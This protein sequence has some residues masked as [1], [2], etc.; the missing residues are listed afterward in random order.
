MI[1]TEMHSFSLKG[2]FLFHPII[3]YLGRIE[4]GWPNTEEA[5]GG[6][7]YYEEVSMS[8]FAFGFQDEA[9]IQRCTLHTAY[10][11]SAVGVSDIMLRF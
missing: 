8:L 7:E 3:G 9:D 6:K 5:V 2:Y 4:L 11:V 1:A 10:V